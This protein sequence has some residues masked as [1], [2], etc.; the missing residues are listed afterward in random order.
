MGNCAKMVICP[1]LG[2]T[3]FMET[4]RR[5]ASD[6]ELRAIA[7]AGRGFVV[8]PFSRQWHVAACPRIRDMTAGQPKW[9]AA[10]PR[11]LEAYL[12]QR[13]ARYATAKPILAC[14]TCSRRGTASQRTQKDP[15]GITLPAIPTDPKADQCALSSRG[16]IRGG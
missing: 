9:F 4:A 12:Q 5:I 13:A 3:P 15:S 8:D 14:R 7:A 10:T 6:G 2:D 1:L 11:A 16:L